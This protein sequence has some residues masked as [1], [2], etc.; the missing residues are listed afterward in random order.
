MA[1]YSPHGPVCWQ[2]TALVALYVEEEEEEQGNLL[3]K[4]TWQ[5]R[6]IDERLPHSGPALGPCWAR[7]ASLSPWPWGPC[8]VRASFGP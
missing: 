1:T 8:E 3:L 7:V 2:P 6:K 5:V 4:A